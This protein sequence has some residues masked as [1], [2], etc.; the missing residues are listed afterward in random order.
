ML[1]LRII[2]LC[3]NK[4]RFVF[5]RLILTSSGSVI[6]CCRLP[7]A[8]PGETVDGRGD[9]DQ[10][11]RQA[12][13]QETQRARCWRTR[14]ATPSRPVPQEAPGR[15]NKEMEATT[16]S[17]TSSN[18]Y[19][20]K[21]FSFLSFSSRLF[22]KYQVRLYARTE[23]AV[24]WFRFIP[25]SK[26]TPTTCSVAFSG[27]DD[28]LSWG[29]TVCGAISLFRSPLLLTSVLW[30]HLSCAVLSTLPIKIL[31]SITPSDRYY[32][33]YVI[34]GK[35]RYI[36]RV[37]VICLTNDRAQMWG[38]RFIWLFRVCVHLWQ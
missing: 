2:F 6:Y 10:T 33:P 15:V 30:K 17:K 35:Q 38:P 37:S 28:S 34:K 8:S 32:Y 22:F 11:K 26:A 31:L 12:L 23:Y 5:K 24:R 3:Y 36:Q 21:W 4:K 9:E 1:H 14:T 20:A 25:K 7:K 18:K 19:A 13:S 27:S 16:I 29:E